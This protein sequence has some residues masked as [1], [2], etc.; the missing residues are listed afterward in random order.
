MSKSLRVLLV[1]D[2]EDDAKLLIKALRHGEI[3]PISDRVETPEA[4]REALERVSWDLIIADYVLPRFSGL[5][6]L[7]LL[8]ET[9]RDIPFIM[10][11]G[12]LG[13]D[14]AVEVM[15]AGAAD[16]ILKDNLARLIP[17]V[18]RELREAG[19]RRERREAE[20]ALR[21]SE[22]IFRLLVEA[23]A[24]YAIFMLDAGGYISSWNTGAQHIKG[25]SAEEIIGQHITIFYTEEEVKRGLPAKNLEAA[26]REGRCEMEGWRLRKDGSL[27]W[28]DMVTTALY[29]PDGSVR[30]YL[31]VVRDMTERKQAEQERERLF[32]EAQRRSAELDASL[33][34]IAD[35]LIIYSPEGEIV[36]TNQIANKLL[37]FTYTECHETVKERWAARCAL[38]P[39]GAPLPLEEIPAELASRRETVQGKV[40]VFPHP[41]GSKIWMS[42]SAGPI[43]AADGRLLGVVST[44]TDIT[45]LHQLQEQRDVYV[46]TISHDLRAPLAVIHGHADL[47]GELVEQHH[48]EGLLESSV[49]AIQRGITRM[50]VMIQDLVDAARMEG[51]QLQLLLQPVG[52]RSYLENLLQRSATAMDV[53]SIRLQIQEELPPVSADYNRLERIFVNLLSNALKY[54]EPDSPIVVNAR[55][56]DDRV[57]ISVIDQGCGIPPEDLIHIFDRFYRVKKARKAEG[58]GL[59]LYI[60]RMLVEAHGGTIRVESEVGEGSTFSFTL[61]IAQR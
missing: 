46:H 8:Q 33:N 28:A 44:Y 47:L 19:I 55:Q 20:A 16:Y 14:T 10:V 40:L 30:G 18:E 24:D 43:Y 23:V 26:A 36:R 45:P 1:E 15:R 4:M 61:P 9:G 42:V 3:E 2:S 32:N 49:A 34:A 38:Q 27:F 31:K 13:E 35:G 54:S 37:G 39:D 48:L 21:E 22:Q 12:K 57:E 6:A 41:D 25:Y 7:H 59:G 51:N 17:A 11:S 56:T 60:T 53:K 52:L 50:N 29:Y 58:I 5:N